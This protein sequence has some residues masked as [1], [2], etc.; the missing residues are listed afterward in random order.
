VARQI[1]VIDDDPV[2]GEL[3]QEALR[4]A[5]IASLVISDSALAVNQI[6]SEKF[7]AIFLDINMPKPDGIQVTQEIR[8]GGV[9]VTTPIMIISGENERALLRRAF[10]AGANFFLYKPIDRHAILRLVRTAE[11]Y[12][13]RER[14]RSGGMKIAT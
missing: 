5:D 11:G 4:S 13:E 3:I 10:E 6:R 12:I 1:L 7:D 8:S 14:Q 9:N 2:T